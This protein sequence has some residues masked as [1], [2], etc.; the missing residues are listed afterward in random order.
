MN[1]LLERPAGSTVRWG[2]HWGTARWE[3]VSPARSHRRHIRRFRGL[4]ILDWA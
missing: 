2:L 4:I 1:H 3:R